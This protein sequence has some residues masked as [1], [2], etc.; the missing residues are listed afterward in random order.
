MADADDTAQQSFEPDIIVAGDEVA[1][2]NA[3]AATERCPTDTR[4]MFELPDD[5]LSSITTSSVAPVYSPSTAI[6]VKVL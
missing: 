3:L 6:P 2:L 4:P 5:S 1:H